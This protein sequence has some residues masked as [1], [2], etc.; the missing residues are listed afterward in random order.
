MTKAPETVDPHVFVLFGATGDLCRRKLL[1]AVFRLTQKGHLRNRHVVLGVARDDGMDE[2]SFRSFARQALEDA[3]FSDSELDTWCDA[4]LFYQPIQ[5]D[6]GDDDYTSLKARIEEIEAKREMPGNR[7]YYLAV[8]PKVFPIVIDG[9]GRHGLNESPGWTRLIIE[10]PFGHDLESAKKLNATVHEWF[11]EEQIYRIDHYLGKETVQNLLVFRFA[12]QVIESQWNRSAI[13][14]VQITVAEDI[15]V[16]TR[17]GY[18]DG[19]GALRDMLQNHLTQVLTLVAMEVPAAYDARSIRNEKIKVLR[20]IRK[21]DKSEVVFG[22]YAAGEIG[23]KQVAGYLDEDNVPDGSRTETFVAARLHIDNWRWQDVPFYVRT[24]KRLAERLTEIIITFRKPPVQFFKS[25]E[26]DGDVR[27]DQLVITLQPDEGFALHV[28]VKHPATDQ[29]LAKVPLSFRYEEAFGKLAD[30]YVTLLLDV[31]TGDQ[32]LFVHAEEVEES[33]TLFEPL[34]DGT[35][36]AVP[37]ASGGWGP[38]E[39]EKLIEDDAG[40]WRV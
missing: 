31:L 20:S 35:I 17:A 37:Y 32:T 26:L 29:D 13:E 36:E 33:W 15:G 1:P 2:R 38:T 34:L 28:D 22:Q 23:G 21:I 19:V 4:C 30:A 16:G 14:N 39:S 25:M 3:G 9:L 12:N 5:G 11:S 10:K 24:G 7:A 6:G 40:R 18:Y 8:P 27:R